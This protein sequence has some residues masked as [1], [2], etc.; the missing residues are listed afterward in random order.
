MLRLADKGA[1]PGLFPDTNYGV[2][3]V[4]TDGRLKRVFERNTNTGTSGGAGRIVFG[5]IVPAN[6]PICDDIRSAI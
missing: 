6:D 5:H 3:I 4:D 1:I 2:Y